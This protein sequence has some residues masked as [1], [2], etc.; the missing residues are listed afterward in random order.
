MTFRILVVD[1]EAALCQSLADTLGH[2]GYAVE[3]VTTAEGALFLAASLN[4]DL[5]LLDLGLPD[6]D[7]K[8]VVRRIRLQRSM[9][10]IILSARDQEEEKVAA[11]EAGADD[12]LTKPFGSAELLARIRV[13]LRH[14]LREQGPLDRQVIGDLVWLPQDQ[15]VVFK[16]T[17]VHLTPLEYRLF[18]F[19]A[20]SPGR[21]LTYG[22]L[23]HEVWGLSN[24][25]QSQNVRVAVAALRRKIHDGEGGVRYIGTEV[26]TGYRFLAPTSDPGEV[27]TSKGNA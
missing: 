1:D 18:R 12:Y 17:P 5:I 26:G 20:S 11:L 4:P 3:T 23:L 15:Q 10:L 16:G 27:K 21:V 8:E 25:D 13:A 14:R 22:T 6:L 24:L 2:H 7:G 9:P 19:L